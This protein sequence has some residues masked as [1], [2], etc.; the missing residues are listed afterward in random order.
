MILWTSQLSNK[1][2]V[3]WFIGKT[4]LI[5]KTRYDLV[6]NVDNMTLNNLRQNKSTKTGKQFNCT[7]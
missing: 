7:V 6:D 2:F 4:L 3:Y 1:G 5:I